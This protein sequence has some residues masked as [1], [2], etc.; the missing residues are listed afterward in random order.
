MLASLSPGSTADPGLNLF[1]GSPA[2]MATMR[3]RTLLIAACAAALALSGCATAP[4]NGPSQVSE[5]PAAASIEQTLAGLG[6]SADDPE[7]LV[8]GLDALPVADRPEGFNVS[9]LPTEVRL[10]PGTPD[11]Q[12][13][14]LSGD[15]FYLSLAP[16]QTQTHPC[17]FHVPTSCIGEMQG[18]EVQL[19]ITDVATGAV[20]LDETRQT[21][22]N[23]F[24]GLWLPRDGEF[25][26]E[27][28]A[29]GVSGEQT[30][31]TG[32][33]DPTCITTLQLQA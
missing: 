32:D 23:G 13:L 33:T 5:Q 31:R 6:L 9:V 10:Q 28:T 15:E 11:E 2:T 30:V 20:V 8:A 7:S 14:P 27:V 24:V 22:D 25:L 4:S 26:I 19:R 1:Y 29:D 16:Y 3:T 17:E 18:A 21:E 12:A